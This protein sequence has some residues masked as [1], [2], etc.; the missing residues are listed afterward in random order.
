[1]ARRISIN[2]FDKNGYIFG[3]PHE[4]YVHEDDIDFTD[5]RSAKEGFEPSAE[6]VRYELCYTVAKQTG[7][8]YFQYYGEDDRTLPDYIIK[9]M[10][11]MQIYYL[12]NE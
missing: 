4:V 1:M 7:I 3:L 5:V 12:T 11:D 9:E 10:I 6:W 2:D 8:L